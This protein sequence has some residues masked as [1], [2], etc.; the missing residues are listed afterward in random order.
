MAELLDDIIRGL[1]ESQNEL[2]VEP[3]RTDLDGLKEQLFG[4]PKRIL[5]D[6]IKTSIVKLTEHS[7]INIIPGDVPS[8]CHPICLGKAY[9]KWNS[10]VGFTGV[11][12][13]II[14]YW[15]QCANKNKDT[16]IITFAWD[17]LDFNHKFKRK[18]DAQSNHKDKTV[19]VVLVTSQGFSIQY[20]R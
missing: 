16:L 14:A 5:T 7:N 19:C 11:A 1:V 3:L 18:F 20:L 9:K 8:I 4:K 12:E 6:D 15:L 2:T 10:K 13:Q 17:E